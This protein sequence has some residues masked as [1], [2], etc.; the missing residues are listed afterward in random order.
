MADGEIAKGQRIVIP[1]QVAKRVLRGDAQAIGTAYELLAPRVLTLATRML[2][3]RGAAEEVVQDTFIDLVEKSRQIRD[4]G[5]IAAWVKQVAVN[6]CL[7]RLRSPWQSRR[8]EFD[9][10]QESEQIQPEAPPLEWVAGSQTLEGALGLLSD[11]ARSVLWLHEVEG[12]THAEIGTLMGRTASFSKSQ[13]A[14]A[15]QKLLEWRTRPTRGSATTEE[16]TEAKFNRTNTDEENERD[17]KRTG[18][19]STPCTP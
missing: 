7:M 6:H 10:T 8:H 9:A 19:F 5:A 11:E 18:H 12:Y 2:H 3:D 16:T 1:L 13:L 17:T 4:P 15:Y 14:R